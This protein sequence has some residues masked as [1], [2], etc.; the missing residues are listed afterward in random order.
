MANKFF[1][2][3]DPCYIVNDGEWD[4]FLKVSDYGDD[5]FEPFKID[6]GEI[7]VCSP[8]KF[9]DGYKIINKV[10]VTVDAGLVC[11]AQ[12]DKKPKGRNLVTQDFDQAMKWFR[13][14]KQ[15]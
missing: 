4:K 15:I 11:V 13:Q 6:G 8:T 12:F 9:G 7:L 5:I 14:A 2:I 1:M 3:T 10:R